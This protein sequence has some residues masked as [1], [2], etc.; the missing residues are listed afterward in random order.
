LPPQIQVVRKLQEYIIHFEGL[1][2]GNHRFD[3]QINDDFFREFF[4]GEM[5][6]NQSDLKAT[7][8]LMKDTSMLV[9]DF[10]ISGTVNLCCDRCL[11]DYHQPIEIR[12]KLIVN[13][14]EE[15][16]QGDD[17]NIITLSRSETEINLA[18]YNYDFIM[19]AIPMKRLCKN[20]ISGC[21]TCNQEMV[22]KLRLYENSGQTSEKIDYRWD[23]LKKLMD[24]N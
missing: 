24:N 2:N 6:F 17:D 19:L 8:H 3:Y 22:E 23:A 14:G 13:F 12:E 15:E 11:D 18:P 16:D 4:D 10:E 5:E 20:D 7:I 21:K 9:F 1:K